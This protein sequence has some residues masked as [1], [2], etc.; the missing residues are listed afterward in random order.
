MLSST[1]RDQI[2]SSK[3][4]GTVGLTEV[5]HLLDRCVIKIVESGEHLLEAGVPNDNLYLILD[6]ELLVHLGKAGLSQHVALGVGDCV[7]ELSLMDGEHASALVVASGETRLL[8]IPHDVVWAMTERSHVMAR[9]L[10]G[11]LAGRMRSNNLAL[12]AS[13]ERSLQFEQV[14]SVDVLTGL[15]N[16]RW[17]LDTF[18]R[19]LLRCRRDDNPLCMI[20]ADIDHFKRFNDRY[21]HLTGDNVLRMVAR[22]LVLGLRPQDMLVRFGG[23][24]FALLLPNTAFTDATSVAERLRQ[25][26]AEQ[27][28]MVRDGLVE[29]VTMSFGV[30]AMIADDSVEKLLAAADNALLEAKR[31]GRNRI[32]LAVR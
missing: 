15:H 17:M 26:V 31:N 13:H 2:Q 14:A 25:A 1:D 9:N 6:G 29:K 16:R 11:I 18:P 27:D 30:A 12:V 22:Q 21:D 8:T 32:E 24:E 10:L 4:F 3:F 23:E 7:G 5:E 19:A 28:F 20:F